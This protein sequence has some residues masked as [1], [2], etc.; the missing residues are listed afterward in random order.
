MVHYKLTLWAA[1]KNSFFFSIKYF[2]TT[3]LSIIFIGLMLVVLYYMPV[4]FLAIFSFMAYVVFLICY[5]RFHK[6]GELAKKHQLA[7]E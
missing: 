6:E 3:L 7:Q 2:P 4:A 1:I 5:S